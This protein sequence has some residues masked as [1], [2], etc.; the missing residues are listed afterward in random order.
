MAEAGRWG[1]TIP[2]SGLPLG[3]SRAILERAEALGYTDLW[4]AEVD[5]TDAF[6]PLALASVWTN[7][8][9]G[10]AIAPSFTRGP[11]TLAVSA[12][13][14]AE[15]APGRFVLGIGTSSDTVVQAW[16]GIPFEQPVARTREVLRALR[17]ALAG[18]RVTMDGRTVQIK[19]FRLSRPV[20]APVPLY[21]AALRARMLRLAG[22][23]ADGVVINWLAPEDV[24]RVVGEARAG[25]ESAGRDP[26]ALDVVCRIFVCL[27]EDRERARGMARR[28]IAAYLNVGVYAAF[29][30]WL[31]RGEALRPMR[32]TW[33]AGD[34]RGALAAIPE[35]IADALVVTGDAATCRAGIR[36]YVEQG[37]TT[38]VIQIVPL[39]TTWDEQ[40]E[41]CLAAVEALAPGGA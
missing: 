4:S 28:M 29:H 31:G 23:E 30:E 7:L 12:A 26:A 24:P 27:S 39:T 2:L 5:A 36:R 38:P 1:L 3:E 10:T 17:T 13:A 8:R 41:E 14:M 11:A 33:A 19:G 6:T 34:R 21:L 15:A 37:V 40:R 32:E 25:A 16:N 35:A 18:E 20:A 22:A 9:L